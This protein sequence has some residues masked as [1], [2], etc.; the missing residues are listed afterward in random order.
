MRGPLLGIAGILG[1]AA[2]APAQTPATVPLGQAR[3]AAGL[4]QHPGADGAPTPAVH[5]LVVLHRVG[6]D[7]AG[8][9]D[10]TYTSGAGAYDF[11]YATTGAPDAVYFASAMYDGIAYFTAP[12]QTA[13]VA[14]PDGDIM[15][16]DTTS[17]GITLSLQGRHI[18]V[19]A[20][21]ADGTREVAE[22]FDLGNEGTKTLIARDTNSPVWTA[23]LPTGARS[24]GVS[25]GDI[26]PG[27]V[28]F[29]GTELRLFA[30]VSPGVRQ[31]GVGFTLPA[32][33]FPLAV[34][35]AGTVGVLELLLEESSA[36]P[37]M[38]GLSQRPSVTSQGR[39]FKRYLAQ[40]VPAGTVLRVAAGSPGG[41][42]RTRLFAGIA[43]AMAIL[44]VVALTIAIRGRAPRAAADT[45]SAVAPVL[46]D[47]TESETLLFQLAQ[48]DA[49]Y[50][51]G[52]NRGTEH[53][54]RHDAERAALKAR[55]ATALAAERRA[56]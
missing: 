44:M 38:P 7:T 18:V 19:G 40:D 48:L 47:A 39:T 6:R 34:P 56:P 55:I 54:A 51:R 29:T 36:A 33:A 30:P 13:G 22:V 24:P 45:P 42:S 14:S 43:F 52:P 12:Y 35:M 23:E 15:V 11:H 53:A 26:A 10:S 9:I 28:T 3:A 49:A 25:G 1:I 20:P 41:G 37:S 32:S 27:A 21:G 17:R 5:Q 8:P 2:A 16:F 46:I 4:V 50:A 31:L